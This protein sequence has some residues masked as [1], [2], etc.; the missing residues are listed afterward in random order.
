MN[1]GQRGTEIEGLIGNG[2]DCNCFLHQ[3]RP[4][5]KFKKKEVLEKLLIVG[6]P[7]EGQVSQSQSLPEEKVSTSEFRRLLKVTDA[8]VVLEIDYVL[9]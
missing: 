8:Q 6:V 9:S 5:R 3:M 2:R 1:S 7:Y 4:K